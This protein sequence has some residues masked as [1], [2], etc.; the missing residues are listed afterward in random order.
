MLKISSLNFINTISTH[1]FL[2][3]HAGLIK[4]IEQFA[5][6][7]LDLIRRFLCLIV[8]LVEFIMSKLKILVF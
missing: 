2:F 3:G 1:I 8:Q 6:R 7:V 4:H 5:F